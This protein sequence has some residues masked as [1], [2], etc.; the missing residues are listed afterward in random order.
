MK[1][2]L[3][4]TNEGMD[5]KYEDT[6]HN[7]NRQRDDRFNQVGWKDDELRDDGCK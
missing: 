1:T 7:E 2:R 5:S 3:E 6:Y 4:K